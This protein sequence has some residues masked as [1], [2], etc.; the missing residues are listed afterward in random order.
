MLEAKVYKPKKEHSHK[1]RKM[2]ARQIYFVAFV[3]G[4][5]LVATASVLA[6]TDLFYPC[7]DHVE[8]LDYCA[9]L[10]AECYCHPDAGTCYSVSTEDDAAG[11]DAAAAGEGTDSAGTAS[12]N[13]T[14]GSS[15]RNGSAAN[16][17][18]RAATSPAAPDNTLELDTIKEDVQNLEIRIA[19]L[20]T[21]IGDLQAKQDNLL[22]NV[23]N[24]DGTLT[25]ASTDQQVLKADVETKLVSVSTGLASLQEDLESAKGD[26]DT[27]QDA[28]ASTPG[29]S[30]IIMYVL[31]I[32]IVIAIG[33]GVIYLIE[34]ARHPQIQFS[35]AVID[36][37]THHTRSGK[38]Y[39]HI[40]ENL[41][42]A[43]WA[44][45]DIERAYKVAM[46]SNYQQYRQSYPQYLQRAPLPSR[47]L[48]SAR[49]TSSSSTL[50]LFA[51]AA[52]RAAPRTA[53]NS[54]SSNSMSNSSN[55]PKIGSDARK[56]AI[57]GGIAFFLV[58]GAALLLS[59]TVGEAIFFSK[60]I[61]AQ[62]EVVFG[63]DCTPPHILTP[64]KDA[65]CL[66]NDAS[67]VCDI[68][69]QRAAA[70]APAS[71]ENTC[72]DSVQCPSG[73]QC[74]GGSCRSLE[75]V[76]QGSPRCDKSCN[77]YAVK[78]I[79]SDGDTVFLDAGEGSYTAVGAIEWQ[80][81]KMPPHCN[82][83]R[84]VVPVKI[85]R[86]DKGKVLNEE[87][88]LLQQGEKSDAILHPTIPRVRFTL[89]IDQIFEQCEDGLCPVQ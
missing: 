39:P 55:S 73:E 80:V 43:G 53:S 2:N 28:V 36:Y 51:A 88:I 23:V 19:V 56:V 3:I 69:E 58:L 70:A 74:I 7:I 61:T 52:S 21:S 13:T 12:G 67:G 38:K 59:N 63:V 40:R 83:E 26:L 9:P 10:G 44:V 31:I 22:S 34:R 4:M 82:G 72:T 66:D 89:T 15:A 18:A 33:L 71:D 46:K 84:A 49:G 45:S 75:N 78:V 86:K 30:K 14:N 50:P 20:E 76:Y 62:G 64:N 65:C 27:L 24:I 37:I 79:T 47:T 87:V 54:M 11:S 17:Q 25:Q 81:L 57:I 77:Y 8:C 35:Q 85:I 16:L 29:L 48:S 42:N 41:A 68:I 6:D 1:K 60:G 5:L 32:L